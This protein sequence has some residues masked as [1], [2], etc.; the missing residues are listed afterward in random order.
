MFEFG[1][2]RLLHDLIE[3]VVL[4]LSGEGLLPFLEILEVLQGK[5]VRD[6]FD[7]PPAVPTLIVADSEGRIVKIFYGAPK[8][9]HDEIARELKQ[10]L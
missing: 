3:P 8:N 6:A 5:N 1:V 2:E 10:T 7:G 4:A 9:L